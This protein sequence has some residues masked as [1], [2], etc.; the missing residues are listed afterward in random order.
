MAS[1]VVCVHMLALGQENEKWKTLESQ[2]GRPTLRR[3]ALGHEERT[4]VRLV[5]PC[6][7]GLGSEL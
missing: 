7:Q 4:S 1:V 2:P 5:T 3:T 6:V